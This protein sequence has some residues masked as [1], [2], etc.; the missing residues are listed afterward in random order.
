MLVGVWIALGSGLVVAAVACIL[1]REAG[2]DEEDTVDAEL[3]RQLERE[4][5]IELSCAQ[6][7]RWPE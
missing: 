6:E 1:V 4:L 7:G 5:E 3:T 2:R